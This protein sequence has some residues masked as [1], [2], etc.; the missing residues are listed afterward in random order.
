MFKYKNS[1]GFSLLELMIAIT[2]MSIIS[3]LL[4]SIIAVNFKLISDVSDR[5]KLVTRGMLA[6]NL[7]Q[8][9]LGMLQH[10]DDIL[11]ATSSQLKFTDAYGN[12]WDYT[13]SGN[14]LNREEVGGGAGAL[15]LATPILNAGTEFSYY[16][17]DNSIAGSIAL[18][19]LV[20]LKLVMDDGSNGIALMS[21]V[22]PE[23]MKI[24]NY[25]LE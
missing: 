5:K 24:Y 22:Y 8:R 10:T 15:T 3:G 23:N 6:I 21:I 19:R 4:V 17:E 1:P 25:P 12:T 9:E 16:A 13:I 18:I 7:F 20:K 2:L 11:V 14:F